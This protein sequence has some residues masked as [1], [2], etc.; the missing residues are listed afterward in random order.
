MKNLI[1]IITVIVLSACA[2]V[3]TIKSVAGTYEGKE[4][5]SPQILRF[6]LLENGIAEFYDDGKK[7][8]EDGKWKLTKEG[9]IH[10]S[11]SDGVALAGGIFVFR[12]NKDGSI[13]LIAEIDDGKR[14]D[15]PKEN[16][17]KQYQNQQFTLKKIK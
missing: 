1:L 6:V 5:S 11:D 10:A 15:V 9:E 4:P 17:G 12:L 8:G 3:P 13:T 7:E 14:E 2:S 16:N